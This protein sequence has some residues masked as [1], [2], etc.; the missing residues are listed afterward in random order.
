MPNN[1]N[2]KIGGDLK[3]ELVAEFLSHSDKSA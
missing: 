1:I 2:F 3:Y